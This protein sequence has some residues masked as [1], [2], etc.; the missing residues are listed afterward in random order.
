MAAH[1]LGKT[2]DA[3]AIGGRSRYSS[4]Q[5][6]E[7]QNEVSDMFCPKCGKELP[8][9]SQFCM[10]CGHAIPV[11]ASE[12]VAA[13]APSLA[14]VP[15]VAP[16]PAVVA[17]SSSGN[18]WPLKLLGA[19]VFIGV[20]WIGARAISQL[21]QKRAGTGSASG[22]S[23]ILPQPRAQVITDGALTVPA[24]N[25]SYYTF[26]VPTDATN[27]SVDGHFTATGGLGNDI[28]VYVLTEDNFVNFKN[29]HSSPTLYNSGKVTTNS[30]S[31]TLPSAGTYYLVFNNNFSLLTPKAVQATATLHFTN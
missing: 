16:A 21:N 8:D 17:K 15:L 1:S 9:D 28:E 14:P 12:P 7:S 27:I 20:L 23:Q 5:L 19:L 11:L 25:F 24:L 6:A 22:L 31:A 26:S 29:G 2:V 10:K 3:I 18:K 30:I 4:V 13:P